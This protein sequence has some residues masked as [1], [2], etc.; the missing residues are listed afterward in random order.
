MTDLAAEHIR[1]FRVVVLNG[2]RQSG[3][4][5][6]LQALHTLLGATFHN[7]DQEGTL[8]AWYRN[9]V[10]AV[11]E[12]DLREMARINEPSAAAVVLRA[13]AAFTSQELAIAR[14][15][16]KTGLSRETVA[17]YVGLLRVVFLVRELP[18]W[19]R[20]LS[21]RMVKHPKVHLIDTG[22]AAQLLGATPE[23]LARP[24]APELGRLTETFVFTELAEQASWSETAVRL[25]HYRDRNGPEVDLILEDDAGRIV[26]IDV[27]ASST[28][29]PQDAKHLAA[30]R[31]R[32]GEQF[33][34]GVV[35]HLGDRTLP[36]GD[37][38]TALPLS[39]LWAP[40][41]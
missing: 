7:L 36:F 40:T 3:K 23:K 30:L 5:T 9:H 29:R 38:I 19:S 35:L 10:A 11:T 20:H 32:F 34:H 25:S 31:D 21:T 4:T 6:V 12:R 8:G 14:V 39:A 28:A 22:L 26:A 1:A 24:G 33:L 16:E 41:N 13:L 27:K 2:P 17:R 37:R 18:G 15:R